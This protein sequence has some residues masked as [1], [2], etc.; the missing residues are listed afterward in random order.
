MKKAITVMM[1]LQNFLQSCLLQLHQLKMRRVLTITK[2]FFLSQT[3]TK[4]TKEFVELEE[5]LIIM[6][7]TVI[8]ILK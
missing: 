2:I 1:V 4:S 6:Q 5:G 7:R 3:I 8:I